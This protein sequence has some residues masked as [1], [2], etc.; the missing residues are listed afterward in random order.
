MTR[1]LLSLLV[2]IAAFLLG[3]AL[4]PEWE[5]RCRAKPVVERATSTEASEGKADIKG[6]RASFYVAAPRDRVLQTLWDVDRFL[7]IFPDIESLEVLARR[8]RGVDAKFTVNAVLAR[9]SYTLRRELD[10]ERGL[11]S[12]REIGGDLAA[13]RGSW[14]VEP[15]AVEGVTKVSYASFVDI[16]RFV[17][18]AM[19]RDL[20]MD[21]VAEMAERVRKASAQPKP[22]VRP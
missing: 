9:V 4:P 16:G 7:E 6:L 11:I 3:A 17:P 5:A 2:V 15:T 18:E 21:K 22:A 19:V 13:V 20:A 14:R 10:E 1:R 8:E 12:W